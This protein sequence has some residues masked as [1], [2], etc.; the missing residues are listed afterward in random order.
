MSKKLTNQ[1]VI[2][3]I[4][5]TFPNHNYDYSQI[6]WQGF[7]K[8]I[9]ITCVNHQ[10]TFEVKLNNFLKFK[11]CCHKSS[12]TNKRYSKSEIIDICNKIHL[13]KYNYSLLPDKIKV[14]QKQHIIC[15]VHGVFKQSISKHKYGRGCPK[16]VPNARKSKPNFIEKAKKIHNNKYDYSLV[17]K[18]PNLNSIIKIYCPFHGM[19]KQKAEYHLQGC[20]CPQCSKEIRKDSFED[21]VRKSNEIHNN[22]FEYDINSFVN[23]RTKTKITCPIHGDFWQTPSS[24]KQKHG[25]PLCGN[26][27]R[28]NSIRLTQQ[29]F[30]S[31]LEKIFENCNYDFSQTIYNGDSNYS[32]IICPKHGVFKKTAHSLL[33]RRAGCPYCKMSSGELKILN[34]LTRHNIKYNFQYSFQKCRGKSNKLPFDFYI[35]KYNTCIEFDGKQHFKPVSIYGGQ[36]A[37]LKIQ[38]SDSIKNKYCH[39][40]QIKLIRISYWDFRN[41]ETILTK[42]LLTYPTLKSS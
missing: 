15:P 10:Y 35:P 1:E 20:G 13:N 39:N 25:C 9:I 30:I 21:F 6:N 18:L 31:R 41:I 16:C 33:Y 24:H 2:Q 22:K 8:P 42:E 12:S 34:F 27:N 36:K 19:F 17:R 26:E 5:K 38:K 40:N 4:Q 14:T 28:E 11:S 29:E 32:E 3:R 7:D 37:F 23:D